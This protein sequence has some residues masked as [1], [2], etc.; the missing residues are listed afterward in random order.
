MGNTRTWKPRLSAVLATIAAVLAGMAV[1]GLIQSFHQRRAG[2]EAR[3]ALNTLSDGIR[4][5]GLGIDLRAVGSLAGS[6]TI[7]G[8]ADGSLAADSADVRGVL[9]TARFLLQAREVYL[10]NAS[11]NIIASDVDPDSVSLS[12][13]SA[14]FSA[15]FLA[16]VRNKATASVSA[17]PEP[18]SLSLLLSAPAPLPDGSPGGILGVRISLREVQ[19]LLDSELDPAFVVSPEGVVVLTNRPETRFATMAPVS[20]AD[21][22][23]F[24]RERGYPLEAQFPPLPFSLRQDQSVR[25]EGASWR[26]FLQPLDIPGWSL[27]ML[28]PDVFPWEMVLASEGLVVLLLVLVLVDIRTSWKRKCLQQAVLEKETAE[29]AT[30]GRLLFVQSIINTI[31]NPV[32]A[33]DRNHCWVL[34]NESMCEIT[35]WRKD[36]KDSLVGRQDTGTLSREVV[37]RIRSREEDVFASE[38]PLEDEVDYLDSQGM[39][40]WMVMRRRAG[41]DDKGNPVLVGVLTD[42]TE[43][44]LAEEEIRLK[45]MLVDASTDMISLVN[46][47]GLV[48]YA[49]AGLCRTLGFKQSDLTGRNI[50]G[51]EAAENPISFK[52]RL[53]GLVDMTHL[54]YET[55]LKTKEG[56]TI[57][58]EVAAKMVRHRDCPYLL[59]SARN[60]TERKESEEER[61]RLEAQMQQAQKLESLGVLAGGIAHDFNNLLMGILG[62]ADLA[63]YSLPQGTRAID[64]IKE[65]ENAARRAAELCRQMLA[66]SG[67]GRFVLEQVNLSDLIGEMTHMIEISISR[68]AVLR[69]NL[70]RAIPCV[71]ADATQLRQLVMNLVMNASEAVAE[72][73]GVISITTGVVE[74][75]TEYLKKT[76]LDD[77][78]PE[79]MYVYLEVSDTGIGMDEATLQRLF[80]PFFSTKFMGRGLGMSAVLGIVRSHSGA[81]NVTSEPGH[82]TRVKIY[83]PASEEIPQIKEDLLAVIETSWW[84][85]GLV[86]L[87][88]DEETVRTVGKRM[89]EHL[90]FSVET[91]GD[92]REAVDKVS[93]L[94]NALQVVVLDLTMPH[95]SGDEAF[96]EI[97]RLRPNL[98]IVLSSG[99][100]EREVRIRIEGIEGVPFIQKPYQVP[101]LRDTLRSVLDPKRKAGA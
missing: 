3:T 58:A 1:Y 44:K 38:H 9:E 94:G 60:I 50:S 91:A 28:R 53:S 30:R 59:I 82:G 75:D 15:E 95:V 92:G 54:V 90:G 36:N 93:A 47:E 18:G 31:P 100:S 70:P 73:S 43:R 69:L 6:R 89:L 11:G 87:V 39:R 97:R 46:L 32:F 14:Q 12:E 27:A 24:R 74:C 42:I 40:R 2:S 88:D 66:Y 98:P 57:H 35:G 51:L 10:W 65:I 22:D 52:D 41:V 85:N 19:T 80:E 21:E 101:T 76:W 78:L 62:N 72:P 7:R 25:F 20:S 45:S 79:G 17:G 61:K 77:D 96:R 83:L 68:N 71:T 29:L 67:K 86:L 8:L 63:L 5:Q 56:R 99:Y 81:I 49:N 23:R 13:T 64:N 48:V 84:G 37:G 26:V 55:R 16:W 34:L 4:K 33:M